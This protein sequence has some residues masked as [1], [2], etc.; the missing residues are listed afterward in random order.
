MAFTNGQ[1]PDYA[2]IPVSGVLGCRMRPGAAAAWEA[3]RQAVH[4][5]RGWWPTQTGPADAYRPYAVQEGLFLARYTTRYIVGRP[6]KRWREQTWYLQPGKATAA[7]PGTSNHGLGITVDI[8][9]LGGFNGTRYKQLATIAESLGWSNAEGRSIGEAWHWTFTGNAEAA[10]NHGAST[11]KVPT[12]PA[13]PAILQPIRETLM[14]DDKII[15]VTDGRA[16][17]FFFSPD[18]NK[19]LP[20]VTSTERDVARVAYET[21]DL[22]LN[23]PQIDALANFVKRVDESK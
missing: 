20:F 9:G 19:F 8:T 1:I 16:A 11:G 7:T 5:A 17:Q 23:A 15:T 21:K 3:L 18:K 12:A 10:S 2:L 4:D 6:T 13:L 14:A 22:Q